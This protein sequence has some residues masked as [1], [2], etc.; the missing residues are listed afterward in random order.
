M[1]QKKSKHAINMKDNLSDGDLTSGD[2]DE[3]EL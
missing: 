1:I 2:S 3:G